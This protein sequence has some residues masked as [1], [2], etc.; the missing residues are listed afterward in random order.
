MTSVRR[1][2]SGKRFAEIFSGKG[3]LARAFA[4]EGIE[5]EEW[6]ILHGNHADFT[7]PAVVERFRSRIKRGI[8]FAV[9][10]GLPCTS[11]SIARKKDKKGPPPLRDNG[12]Y[13][14]SG[15]PNLSENDKEKVRIGNQLTLVTV[16]LIETCIE[17]GV[18]V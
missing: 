2:L 13:L 17:Y 11:W 10:F 8:Y 4:S 18:T 16:S 9:S 3:H 15:L 14:W 1:Q 5:S 12:T 7:N 6:D